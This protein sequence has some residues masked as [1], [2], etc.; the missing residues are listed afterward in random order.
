MGKALKGKELGLRISTWLS[1][2]MLIN[3]RFR[4]WTGIKSKDLE[5]EI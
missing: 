5:E 2:D 1:F 4:Y 3:Q